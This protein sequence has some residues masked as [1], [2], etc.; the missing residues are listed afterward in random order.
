MTLFEQM[1]DVPEA[2]REHWVTTRTSGRPDLHARLVAL[3]AADRQS[4]IQT[5]GAM[6]A[7]HIEAT[8]ERIGAYKITDLIGRGGMGSVYRGERDSGDFTRTVAIKVIKAGL[9]S[10]EVVRRFQSER[11]TLATLTHPNIAALYDGGET[12]AG[13]PY[14]VMEFVDGAPLLRWAEQTHPA[15]DQRLRIFLDMC[16]AVAFAH[17]RLIVHRDISPANVLVTEAG[18]AKLIDFGI[19]KPADEGVTPADGAAAAMTVTPGYTAPERLRSTQVTTAADIFS[20]GRLL[21]EFLQPGANENELR[22]IVRRATADDPAQRYAS[23][24]ALVADLNA[25]RANRPVAAFS[26]S[27]RYALRK[28]AARH[29]LAL[30]ASV[31]AFL[32]LSAALAA[33]LEANARAER[34]RAD[35]EAR[36]EQT[37]AIAKTMLFDVF[38]DVSTIVGST[39]ARESLARTGLTYLE[40]LAADERA[41]TD[42]RIEAGLGFLRLSQVVGGGQVGELGRYSDAN[43]LLARSEEILAPLYATEPRDPEVARAMASLLAEKAGASLY[44]DNDPAVARQ[45]AER[46]RDIIAPYAREDARAA[47]LYTIS[48]QAIGDSYGWDDD[49]AQ[50]QTYH[51]QAETFVAGLPEEMRSNVDVMRARAANLRLLGEAYHRLERVEDARV[52]LDNVVALQREIRATAPDNPLFIRNLA[53]ALWFRA[54]VHRTNGRD[55]AA[56]ASIEESVANARLLRERD[57]NDAG[58]IRMLAISS[59]VYAQVLGDLGQFQQSFAVGEDVIAAHRELVRRADG[60]PGARR[61]L[62]AALMTN[63]GNFYN[64][65]AY[66]RACGRWAEGRGIYLQLDREGA[67]SEHDRGHALAEA[68]DLIRRACDP[69]RRGLGPRI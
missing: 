36:F 1:L 35:A 19:A 37:R 51:L 68:N 5:G 69:P 4:T 28:F 20:L 60:A 45:N 12:E 24:D 59:E 62:A 52:T 26:A 39:Q 58:A 66:A 18:I 10:P 17:A 2:E 54:V 31:G 29:R 38:D 63:G 50:A 33:T 55:A 53:V 13:S 49:Y 9:F 46:G 34:E 32:A 14:I 44:N 56:R 41:P 15:R 27:R 6:T 47:R 43:A 61:S 7:V 40:S 42:V 21:D 65:A 48:L 3:Q 30:V 22:A 64:G 57:P 67:L 8:P 16:G 23:V 11:Q 25:L